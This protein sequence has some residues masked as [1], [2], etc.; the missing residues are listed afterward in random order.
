MNWWI[1]K[2]KMR[3]KVKV[4][5]L[6]NGE[7]GYLREMLKIGQREKGKVGILFWILKQRD[8][9]LCSFLLFTFLVRTMF[10]SG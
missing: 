2:R 7:I 1:V 3:G 4:G 6:G 10:R 5:A 8:F 9:W